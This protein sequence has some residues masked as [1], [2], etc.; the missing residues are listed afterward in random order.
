LLHRTRARLMVDWL[1]G[2]LRFML[3]LVVTAG[4]VCPD[5]AD[6][7]ALLRSELLSTEGL[8][9]PG[10][11]V[12]TGRRLPASSTHR[13]MVWRETLKRLASDDMLWPFLCKEP[14][15]CRCCGVRLSELNMAGVGGGVDQ[16]NPKWLGLSS[17]SRLLGVAWL[18]QAS[19]CW[20][21]M[22]TPSTQHNGFA[23]G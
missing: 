14:I 12:Q 6:R 1:T 21:H 7:L 11:S 20:V 3:I 13:L 4:T 2:C 10:A 19:Y 23:S 22:T 9:R 5:L 16:Q 17:C 8:P 15:S 18:R